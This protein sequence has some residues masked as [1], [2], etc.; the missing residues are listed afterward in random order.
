MNFGAGQLDPAREQETAAPAGWRVPAGRIDKVGIV[1]ALLIAGALLFQPFIAFRA[2]RIVAGKSLGLLEALPTVPGLIGLALFAGGGMFALFRSPP[3][4]RLAA[5]AALLLALAVL[6]GLTPGYLVPPGNSLARVSAGSGFWVLL[7]A[8]ALLAADAIA[9]LALRP[10]ARIAALALAITVLAAIL[11]SGWW[12]GLSVMREYATRSASF[13]A[14][15]AQHVT[16]AFGS[17]AAAVIVGIPLGIAAHRHA[18]LRGALLPVLNIVQ[19]IP[20]MAMYGLMMVPLGLL[21]AS[22]PLAAALGIRGIG[23]APA[24]L[25]LFLYSLL[26]VVA[27]VVVGLAQVPAQTVEAARGMGMTRNE[28]LLDVELPLALPVVLTGIRIVLVQN[29]GLATIAALIGGGG[30][31]TFVFQGIGQAATDLVLLGA[32]PTI[33][34]A[35]IAAILLDAAIDSTRGRQG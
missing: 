12:D 22:V 2:N 32:V 26:P 21:A 20:S 33:M 9:R 25:A 28:I 8:V 4:L 29:I 13:W 18:G 17:L 11:K 35:F 19:T 14:E 3:S 5:S 30:F 31:G 24:L 34:L 6:L 15:A 1:I 23:T 7:F 16:L 27:N 10:L